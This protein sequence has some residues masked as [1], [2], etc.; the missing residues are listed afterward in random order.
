MILEAQ[1]GETVTP[2]ERPRVSTQAAANGSA[3]EPAATEAE[4]EP[5][6]EDERVEAEAVELAR[7]HALGIPFPGVEIKV[8][9]HVARVYLEDLEVECG[10]AVLR[11][12]IRVVLERA[13]ETVA[14]MWTE[15]VRSRS[16]HTHANGI[17][18]DQDKLLE[19][20]LAMI[21]A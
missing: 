14:S 11:D 8:D 17:A 2:I 20:K 13:V 18:Y 19:K 21:E 3:T 16:G 4:E 6:S 9:T 1:F 10:N 15:E 12:R 7:L 5:L